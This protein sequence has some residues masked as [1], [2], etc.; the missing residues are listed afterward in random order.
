M[1][2]GLQGAH[3]SVLI[4]ILRQIIENFE[5][6][7]GSGGMFVGMYMLLSGLAS[8]GWA[9]YS[10]WTGLQRR[11]LIVLGVLGCSLFTILS[12]GTPIFYIFAVLY[13]LAGMSISVISPLATTIILDITWRYERTIVIMAFSI[14]S[15]IG[16]IFGFGLGLITTAIFNNWRLPIAILAASIFIVS[17][18]FAILLKEPPKGFSEEELN[19]ILRKTY[20]YPFTL[21]PKDLK[22]ITGNRSNI[23]ATL[24]GIF[25]IIG[26]GSIE[27][28]ILQYLVR[29]AHTNEIVASILM[30]LGAIGGLPGLAIAKL[31]DLTSR[32]MNKAKPIIA[33]ICS[34]ITASAFLIFLVLPLNLN[35]ETNDAVMAATYLI[36]ALSKDP[37]LSTAI[38][39]FFIAM[40]SNSPIGPIKVAILSEVNL[41]EH[42]ATVISGSGIIELFSKSLGIAVLGLLVDLLGSFRIPL[43]IAVSMWF[44]SAFYWTKMSKTITIDAWKLGLLLQERKILLLKFNDAQG[45]SNKS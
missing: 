16:Y 21:S 38:A 6:S 27:V 11:V 2:T 36:E 1:L 31:A 4:P 18:P 33:A 30:G 37:L 28:W 3:R 29:E 45:I 20:R 32:R 17:L 40:V 12:I 34:S 25:G 8:L 7:Y 23:F 14:I 19:E 10:D 44:V 41:P 39:S 22:V 13:I 24:Q 9:T 15:G 43:M 35:F 26:S 5:I 42:R